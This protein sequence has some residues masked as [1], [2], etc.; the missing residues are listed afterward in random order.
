MTPLRGNPWYLRGDTALRIDPLLLRVEAETRDVLPLERGSGGRIL[1]A[2]SGQKGEPYES[3]R[4]EYCYA[5]VG[6]R[7]AETAGGKAKAGTSKPEGA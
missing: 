1:L 2:F 7:D 3:V 4:R 5:S 6:E